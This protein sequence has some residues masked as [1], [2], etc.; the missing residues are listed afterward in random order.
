MR[1]YRRATRYAMTIN[2]ISTSAALFQNTASKTLN[3]T[4]QT[5]GAGGVQQDSFQFSGIAKLMEQLKELQSS[6]PT[7]YKAVT[8]KIATQ[9]T[10]AAKSA[11]TSGDQSTADVLNDL[12]SK[13]TNA[14]KT[15]E[16]VDLRPPGAPP[17]GGSA[18]S[19]TDTSN[20]GSSD[21]TNGTSFLDLFQASQ[22]SRSADP[23]T[24]LSGILQNAL[25]SLSAA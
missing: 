8:A 18:D 9:L 10:D 19:S 5:S 1:G 14:S 25:S 7:Q 15:G 4:S 17:S 21:S 23:M 13:F 24:T 6:D 11:A 2:S 12:A 20:T 22:Q 16:Q 3:S